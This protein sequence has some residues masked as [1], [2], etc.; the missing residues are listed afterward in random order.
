MPINCAKAFSEALFQE[1]Q[2]ND[3]VFIVTNDSVATNYSLEFQT[4]FPDRMID[5][6]IAEQNMIG[7]ASGLANNG[8]IPFVQSAA[9]FLTA[10]ALEQIKVD[11]AYANRNVKLCGFNSGLSYAP[12][13][14]THH[15]VDDIAWLRS[16]PNMTVIVPGDQRECAAAARYS[17]NHD[18]PVYIRLPNIEV[19]DLYDDQIAPSFEA[20][21]TLREGK[22]VTIIG[23]GIA[24]QILSDAAEL[25]AQQNISARLLHM[26]AVSPCDLD[27]IIRAGA[28]IGPVAVVEEHSVLGGLGSVVCE[29]TSQH[30]PVKVLRLGV[31]HE[32]LPIGKV[33]WLRAHVGLNAKAVAANVSEWLSKMT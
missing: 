32:F 18:G 27:S 25:L 19:P 14:S 10:R 8:K 31:P 28:E 22:D 13:G 9:C 17:L 29:V 7:V 21:I 15:S 6:G 24:S 4:A 26:A 20:A 1:S 5:V 33:D 11:V 2:N 3:D 12:L 30:C 23:T 16:I